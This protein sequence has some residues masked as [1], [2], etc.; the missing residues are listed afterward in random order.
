MEEQCVFNSDHVPP[1]SRDL[2]QIQFTYSNFIQWPCVYL[3][4]SALPGQ[5]I[6]C[7]HVALYIATLFL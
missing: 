3:V 6:H 1:Q 5:Q 4:L 2:N 7:W